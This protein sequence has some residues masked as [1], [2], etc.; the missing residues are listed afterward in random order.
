MLH[1]LTTPIA[2][3]L[4]LAVTTPRPTGAADQTILGHQLVVK[5]PSTPDRRQLVVKAREPGSLATIVG[6][7]THP[8]TSLSITVN[9]ATPSAQT[10]SLPGGT[11]PLTGKP[12]WHGDAVRGF[13]YEDSKGE[14]GALKIVRLKA[15]SRGVFQIAAVAAGTLGTIAVV[16]PNPGTDGCMRLDIGGGG[17]T[18]HVLFADGQV[19]N[20]GAKQFK[21]TKPTVEGTCPPPIPPI[22]PVPPQSCTFSFVAKWGTGVLNGQFS[23]PTGVAVD[24]SGN[25]FVIDADERIQKF[26]NTGTFLTTWGSP[27]SGDGQFGTLA[28]IAVDGSG[29]VY[30]AD[31]GTHRIQ[32]FTNTG[33]FLTAWGSAGT[34]DG[35]FGGP[36]GQYLG[37][38]GV[39]VDGSGN[40]FVVD[41]GND[42][43]QKFTNTG[44]FL[45]AWGSPGGGDGQF[46]GP[47]DVAVD[48]SGNVFVADTYSNRI[49]KFDSTGT[50]LT[51]W[52]GGD[53]PFGFPFGIAV[54]GSGNVFVAD[55]QNNRIQKFTNTGTFLTTWGSSGSGDGQFDTPLD[56]AVDG[57]GNVFVADSG[58]NNNRIQKFDSTGAFL[59]TWGSRSR[60]GD[61][62]F[63]FPD[64]V[65]VDGSGNVFVADSDNHR[66][67][68][69]DNTGTF[70]TTWG[71]PGSGDG[72]F[73][74]LAGIAVDGSGNVFVADINNSRI[75]KFTNTGTFVTTWGS[76]GTGDGQGDDLTGVAVDGS[77]N[78][79]VTDELF[80]C[81][82]GPCSTTNNRVQKFTNTGTFLTTW[83]SPGSRRWAVQRPH[84]ASPWM[85]AATSS[86]STP[87]TT[88]SRSSRTLGP[89]SPRGA[90]RAPGTGSSAAPRASPWMGAGT[91]TS[92]TPATTASRGSRAPAPSSPP[93][94]TWAAGTGSSAAPLVSRCMGTGSTSWIRA[95]TASRSSRAREERVAAGARGSPPPPRHGE[96]EFPGTRGS[97]CSARARGESCPFSL[98]AAR[99]S[100]RTGRYLHVDGAVGVG[101]H[102]TRVRELAESRAVRPHR[103]DLLPERVRADGIAARREQDRPTDPIGRR[104]ERPDS[105]ARGAGYAT[106][107]V[108]LPHPTEGA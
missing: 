48:G 6:D 71:S 64:G 26:D 97:T 42:R 51:A 8:G 81:G 37:P 102:A 28:G 86:S 5:N 54:D 10:F 89:S 106:Q 32:K 40:V 98:R 41:Y 18:Y 14:N 33:T 77:G 101:R 36:D 107:P 9:G 38:N 55:T 82:L 21:V 27:G 31:S 72:Q 92:S 99:P 19:T 76:Q 53:G 20:S 70:L 74:T 56:V 68:K 13:T 108:R 22:P 87:A 94:A 63:N 46:V 85:G 84:L 61:G 49:Q 66:I 105:A 25:V 65:A 43:I 7:P 91:F 52:G 100:T 24:G 17:D 62:Q 73:G 34:G 59:T 11:S 69:F 16:P 75:Q 47:E 104:A 67:Q 96:V 93:G 2:L 78:V 103:E 3:V 58:Y 44:T 30:V 88:G 23:R 15:S 95:T 12:F 35:Q 60:S 80:T 1:S 57:S 50:F 4:V 45:T 79:F 90:A 83:G 39:A 29:N